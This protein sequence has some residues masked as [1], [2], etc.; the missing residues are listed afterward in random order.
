M[1][2]F[3]NWWIISKTHQ[4]LNKT[5]NKKELFCNPILGRVFCC[6]Y[7]KLLREGKDGET[8][9]EATESHSSSPVVVERGY[10][11]NKHVRNQQRTRKKKNRMMMMKG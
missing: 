5:I 3:C 9:K 10:T 11:N 2:V 6:H 1:V 7:I 8:E 4:E